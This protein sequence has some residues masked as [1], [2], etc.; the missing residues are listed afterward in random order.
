MVLVMVVI[1]VV[2]AAMVVVKP[3]WEA[4]SQLPVEA[5]KRRPVNGN[6]QSYSSALLFTSFIWCDVEW[7]LSVVKLSWSR[8]WW[9]CG[10][11]L[12]T[13]CSVHITHIVLGA[14]SRVRVCH[15]L[16]KKKLKIQNH[17][18]KS[19]NKEC[20]LTT[21][22]FSSL[23]P[24]T[25]CEKS[26]SEFFGKCSFWHLTINPSDQKIWTRAKNAP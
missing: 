18:N 2:L 4:H 5:E 21:S 17:L 16:S 19:Q 11:F 10:N 9:S 3:T 7:L 8:W 26:E 6:K 22:P 25:W 13:H 1:L 24:A 15:L 23:S 12:P 20:E 14:V